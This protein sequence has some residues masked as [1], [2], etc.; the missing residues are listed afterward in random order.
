MQHSLHDD[1]AGF[2][3]ASDH[4]LRASPSA[5]ISCSW[6]ASTTT[7]SSSVDN[8]MHA[9]SA[10]AQGHGSI[11][12]Q[13]FSEEAGA[14]A[15]GSYVE[16]LLQLQLPPAASAAGASSFAV[17]SSSDVYDTYASPHCSVG[18]FDAPQG[19]FSVESFLTSGGSA[20]ESPKQ[21]VPHTLE[22]VSPPASST[23]F[24]GISSMN[25]RL[26]D[27]AAAAA[28][29]PALRPGVHSDNL[30]YVKDALHSKPNFVDGD[31]DQQHTT[32]QITASSCKKARLQT[33]EQCSSAGNDPSQIQ[34]IMSKVQ[35]ARSKEKLGERINALQQLVSPFGKTD[36]ASVL[37]EAIGY[38]KFLQ[39]QVQV[40][41][42]PYMKPTST[43]TRQKEGG[44]ESAS[45][46]RSRGLC[47][48][49]VACTMNV[50]NNNNIN[51]GADYWASTPN[52][53]GST[54]TARFS[55]T[56]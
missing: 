39:E 20:S 8:C 6:A 4:D 56:S 36:T 47:L 52:V 48:V 54:P 27:A 40:L 19:T 55:A 1:R 24:H 34:A 31:E 44:R 16:E 2:P 42:S 3:A 22:F 15:A 11:F 33:S 10:A 50:A 13:L 14:E 30:H 49:P 35:S 5:T 53:G 38:I 41:S 17:L 43:L 25:S 51:I 28:E 37:S 29:H 26:P 23:C 12:R 21:N 7:C 46:L 9:D 18:D 32:P 45:D